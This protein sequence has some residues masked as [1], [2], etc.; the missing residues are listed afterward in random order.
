MNWTRTKDVPAIASHI[1]TE[2]DRLFGEGLLPLL[3]TPSSHV[4][5]DTVRYLAF[6]KVFTKDL[7]VRKAMGTLSRD[8]DSE[9]SKYQPEWHPRLVVLNHPVWQ[10]RAMVKHPQG[11]PR[12][13]LDAASA[14]LKENPTAESAKAP[15]VRRVLKARI[16]NEFG[17]ALVNHGGGDWKADITF[18]GRKRRLEFDFGGMGGGVRHGVRVHRD[19]HR[20]PLSYESA[21]GFGWPQ[22]DLLRLDML[23]DQITILIDGILRVCEWLDMIDGDIGAEVS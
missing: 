22:W 17:S 5:M 20:P 14:F 21:L 6:P 23:E 1:E 13:F 18:K 12:D 4:A 19:P 10:L 7:L 2:W 3:R 11:V 15:D 16:K 9:L 8:E